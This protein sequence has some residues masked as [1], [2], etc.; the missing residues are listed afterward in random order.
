MFSIG[1]Y[2][3][4]FYGQSTIKFLYKKTFVELKKVKFRKVTV[5]PV[6]F[7]CLFYIHLREHS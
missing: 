5:Q 3:T 1:I 6:D 7:Y 4:I 2:E